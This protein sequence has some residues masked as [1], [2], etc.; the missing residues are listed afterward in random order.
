MLLLFFLPIAA[1]NLFQQFYNTADA[2]IIAKF[3]GTEALAAVGGSPAMVI[4][5]LIGFF[6]ALSGGAGVVIA[7]AY[8]SNN[9]ERI[10]S[11]SNTAIMMSLVLGV[12]FTAAGYYFTPSIL[13]AMRTPADTLDGAILYLRIYFCGMLFNML[14][15]MGSGILRA[16]GDSKRPLY[17]LIACCVTN[18]VLDV[19]LVVA[20]SMGVAGVAL[21]TV[22][23]QFISAVIVMFYLFRSDD[24]YRV[25]FRALGF[26]R[27]SLG[28]MLR[29]GIPSGLQS[30]MYNVSN[31]IIQVALN[32]LG[33]VVVA[34]WS[35]TGKID[36]IYWAMSSA[37]GTAIT[38]FVGQNY[39]AGRKDRIKKCANEGMV[40]F[41]LLTAVLVAIIL[42]FGR[43]GMHL[44]IDDADVMETTRLMLTYFVP[45]YFLWTVIEVLSAV[46][47]GMGD[48]LIP[49]I[50]TALGIC[51]F[52]MLWIAL[53]FPAWHTVKGI[54]MCYPASWFV[55]ALA[56]FIYYTIKRRKGALK[57]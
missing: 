29:I 52:R 42:L 55:T 5:V 40:S 49:V 28:R 19:V 7:Q 30:S 47:R 17:V 2:L 8:G 23:S 10:S 41:M 12:V 27:D 39:G 38:S 44:L 1:G 46:L 20:F 3:V 21:A 16:V 13:E 48:T 31:L 34:S 24:A 35:M 56:I 4:N 57:D 6:T 9:K 45:Y 50:I 25:T 33:T 18:I 26:H 36:G 54:S 22:F 11:A 15:N 43:F 14:Y 32:P 37:L 51:G 53:V